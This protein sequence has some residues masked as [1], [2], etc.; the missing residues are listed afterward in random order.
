MRIVAGKYKGHRL[1]TPSGRR[2]RPTADRTREAIFNVLSHA[3]WAPPLE[4]AAIIDL[5]AGSGALGFE[6][7]SRGGSHCLFVETEASARGAIRTNAE[8]LQ[9]FG[10]TQVHRRSAISLG[11]M[12]SKFK[13][14]FNLAFLDPPYGKGLA[15]LSLS[16]LAKG[17]WMAPD[18]M[19]VVETGVDEAIRPEGWESVSIR[20]YGSAQIIFLRQD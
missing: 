11:P 9:V 6:A 10:T 15:E 3:D 7:L 12:P 4:G 14:A 2:T 1:T 5:F 19:A 17:G 13:T 16:C 18:S 20:T 8:A